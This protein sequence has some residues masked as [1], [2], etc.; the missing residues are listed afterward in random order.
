MPSRA[1][2]LYGARRDFAATLD[3][4]NDRDDVYRV[5]LRA[6]ERLAATA[7]AATTGVVP[8]LS[9]W[10]PGSARARPGA[11]LGAAHPRP[12]GRHEPQLPGV[13][14]GWYLLDA[15]LAHASRGPYRLAVTKSR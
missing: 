9:L 5:Y 4:W 7:P 10:R 12:P 15:R 3:Y 6:G 8:S 1:Y 2:P 14:A 11:G 13:V